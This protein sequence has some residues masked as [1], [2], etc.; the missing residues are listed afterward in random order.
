[1]W[2]TTTL[3]ND[4]YDATLP[5][6]TVQFTTSNIPYRI[7][8]TNDYTIENGIL[9]VRSYYTENAFGHYRYIQDAIASPE[10]TIYGASSMRR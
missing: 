1:M 5:S 6:D 4:G 3:A 7:T 2:V 8:Y 10:Y 9:I